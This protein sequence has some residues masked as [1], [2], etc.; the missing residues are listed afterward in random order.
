MTVDELKPLLR[1]A[2]N[3]VAKSRCSQGH[4]VS[5]IWDR[6]KPEHYGHCIYCK[7]QVRLYMALNEA[8]GSADVSQE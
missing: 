3:F 8:A 6:A 4:S 7:D 1:D 2:C 5:E